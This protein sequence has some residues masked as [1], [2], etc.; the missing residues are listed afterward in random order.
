MTFLTTTDLDQLVRA[1][2]R[3]E[4]GDEDT[5]TR[6]ALQ[7]AAELKAIAELSDYLRAR[8]DTAVDYAKSGSNRDAMLVHHTA[9]MAL[10]YLH[11]RI[12]Q[13][14]TPAYVLEMRDE[15]V[16]WAKE[17][18]DAMRNPGLTQRTDDDGVDIEQPNLLRI[19]ERRTKRDNYYS[20]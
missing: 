13:D 10:Y 3:L 18:R 8:Y 17:C 2:Q 20:Y 9:A 4:I 16:K 15:A 7:D 6:D 14:Q 11:L 19:S 1:D 12:A 5:A